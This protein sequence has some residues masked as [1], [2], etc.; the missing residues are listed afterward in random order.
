[1]AP[2][3]DGGGPDGSASSQTHTRSRNGAAAF[4]RRRALAGFA[5]DDLHKWP[6]FRALARPKQGRWS[7]ACQETREIG[8]DLGASAGRVLARHPSARSSDDRWAAVG[9][10]RRCSHELDGCTVWAPGFTEVDQGDAVRSEIQHLPQLTHQTNLLDGV[11]VADVER[12]L[13]PIA[14]T[15]YDVVNGS[16]SS[17]V[18]DVICN[19]PPSARTHRVTKGTYSGTSPRRWAPSNRACTSRIRR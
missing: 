5:R 8:R 18:P 12:V 7:G 4:R 17:V 11:K 1:M 3:F 15:S 10:L 2:P 13:E 14:V 16:K 9:E 6:W 19:Q